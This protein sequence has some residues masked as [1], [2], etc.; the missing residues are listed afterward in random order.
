MAKNKKQVRAPYLRRMKAETK[1]LTKLQRD[2]IKLKKVAQAY[3][4]AIDAAQKSYDDVHWWLK[5]GTEAALKVGAS[6]DHVLF[7]SR[8]ILRLEFESA[9]TRPTALWQSFAIDEIIVGAKKFAKMVPASMKAIANG[10]AAFLNDRKAG[11]L[12]GVVEVAIRVGNDE[13]EKVAEA[14]PD[15]GITS[16][17]AVEAEPVIASTPVEG[18]AET[19]VAQ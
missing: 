9:V 16:E 4:K 18:P 2:L 3:E 13:P 7:T 14:L 19:A 15:T 6:V 10:E 12:G 1:K 11:K 8:D 17:T 5:D